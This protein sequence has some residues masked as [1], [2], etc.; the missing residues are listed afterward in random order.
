MKR[1][2]FDPISLVLGLTFGGL[3][4]LFLIGERTAADIGWRWIW[5]FPFIVLGL[6]FVISAARRLA[7]EA[8]AEPEDA[9]PDDD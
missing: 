1:H 5:P 8:D 7:P 6:L 3:G 4:L 2:P 9:S